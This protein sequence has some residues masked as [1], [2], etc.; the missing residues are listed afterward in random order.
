MLAVRNH[1]VCFNSFATDLNW[2]P[3]RGGSLFPVLISL[4]C[5]FPPHLW[6]FFTIVF[7]LALQFMRGQPFL[8]PIISTSCVFV[9]FLIKN[10]D[11]CRK[12]LVKF[13]PVG[14]SL[15]WPVFPRW[16]DSLWSTF[17]VYSLFIVLT[18]TL[19]TDSS[20]VSS[21]SI[22]EPNSP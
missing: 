1:Q 3:N 6:R 14:L 15:K 2:H 11:F 4:K 18:A 21:P 8:L 20:W 10:W 7:T 22:T 19:R 9:C 12:T 5:I 13:W 16:R 17:T